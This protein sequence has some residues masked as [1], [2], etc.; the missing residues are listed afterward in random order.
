MLMSGWGVNR[1]AGS[2]APP[3]TTPIFPYFF[4]RIVGVPTGQHKPSQTTIG[5]I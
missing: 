2:P 3:Y 1:F 4:Y 5:G